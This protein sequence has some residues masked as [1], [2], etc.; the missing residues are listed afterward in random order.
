M[1]QVWSLTS[2]IASIAPRKQ[3]RSRG[4]NQHRPKAVNTGVTCSYRPPSRLLDTSGTSRAP[5]SFEPMRLRE[6]ALMAAY[7][8]FVDSEGILQDRVSI[9][10]SVPL[11]T[12]HRQSRRLGEL[13]GLHRSGYSG[14]E[15]QRGNHRIERPGPREVQMTPPDA[16]SRLPLDH[17][18]DMG[19]YNPREA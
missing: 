3:G 14:V 7:S 5:K 17:E 2:K 9:I 4:I 8:K 16:M 15:P 13:A 10:R 1:Y 6:S 19:G 12:P 18:I 11:S